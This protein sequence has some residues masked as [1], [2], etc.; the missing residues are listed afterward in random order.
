MSNPTRIDA[1]LPPNVAQM[2]RNAATKA[3]E[4]KVQV[5]ITLDL[6]TGSCQVEAPPDPVLFYGMLELARD[7]FKSLMERIKRDAAAKAAQ[8]QQ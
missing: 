7:T 1:G 8:E 2:V 6:R 4:N 3:D 5:F